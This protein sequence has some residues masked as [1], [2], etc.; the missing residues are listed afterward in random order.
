MSCRTNGR[1]TMTSDDK[2]TPEQQKLVEDYAY[3]VD[4]TLAKYRIKDKADYWDAG[5][6]G[7]CSAALKWN[8]EKHFKGDFVNFALRYIRKYISYRCER[9]NKWI[10][11][12]C[13]FT[14]Y[15]D[16]ESM[17]A[18]VCRW[19]VDDSVN[20]EDDFIDKESFNAFFES[21]SED[22]Q[23]L[24]M[25]YLNGASLREMAES[26]GISHQA[27]DCRMKNWKNKFISAYGTKSK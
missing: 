26:R 7:L 25:E 14:P 3:L 8:P 11:T 15:L 22:N 17:E 13:S 2:L 10:N 5:I 23:K 18:E 16:E 19:W 1:V 4:I 9:V 20:L 12:T 24:L 6:L 21:L 27:V